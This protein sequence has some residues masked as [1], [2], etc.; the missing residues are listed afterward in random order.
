MND[1][2]MNKKQ[3]DQMQFSPENRVK[4]NGFITLV[5][6][7]YRWMDSVIKWGNRFISSIRNIFIC[8]KMCIM[9]QRKKTEL[10]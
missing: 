3:G 6:S 5:N 8:I 2:V 9:L 1:A 4:E 7:S 10:R